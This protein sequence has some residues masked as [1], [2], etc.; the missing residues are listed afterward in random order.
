MV[1]D[2][3]DIEHVP[4]GGLKSNIPTAQ[5]IAPK[6]ETSNMAGS[7]QHGYIRREP[8][9]RGP[10]ENLPSVQSS[11]GKLSAVG[12]EQYQMYPSA[13]EET[14]QKAVER[15]TPETDADVF[16]L[17]NPEAEP[18]LVSDNETSEVHVS[19]PSE[20]QKHLE[21]LEQAKLPPAA[22]S[23]VLSRDPE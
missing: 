6:I 15:E 23:K 13:Y 20:V 3:A 12:F 10:L 21:P 18:L 5:I 17:T 7:I 8:M 2:F 9:I 14:I 1:E 11:E 16:P 19:I 4:T 22:N